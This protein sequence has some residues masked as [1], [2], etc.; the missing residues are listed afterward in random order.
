MS[1]ET[2]NKSL[3]SDF[4]TKFEK[5][6]N[7][8]LESLHKVTEDADERNVINSFA[9]AFTNQFRELSA[10]I[11][12]ESKRATKQGLAEAEKFLRISSGS[13]LAD[14]L[15]I[16]LP[17]IG[18]LVGKLGISGII[19]EIKKIVMAILDVFNINL[20]SWLNKLINLIDEILNHIL[21]AGSSK[22]KAELGRQEAQ[23]LTELRLVANLDKATSSK[24]NNDEEED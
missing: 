16:S 15:K 6:P 14:N 10:F 5:I 22:T 12:E 23:Y 24:F 9:P 1:K 19:Q 17:S 18:S 21:G 3:L 4:L 11:G 8:I 13:M 7:D 2:S 20:P